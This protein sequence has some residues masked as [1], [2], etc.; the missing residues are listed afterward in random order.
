MGEGRG[1]GRAP[2]SRVPTRARAARVALRVLRTGLTHIDT[3]VPS[4]PVFLSI[5]GALSAGSVVILWTGISW[6]PCTQ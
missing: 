4:A 6:S 3:N 1:P 2:R 5:R